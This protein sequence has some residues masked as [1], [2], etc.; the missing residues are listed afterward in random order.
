M[1]SSRYN[2]GTVNRHAAA[3]RLLAFVLLL[4]IGYGAGAEVAHDH[5][6]GDLVS[7][8]S[9]YSVQSNSD[10][11]SSSNGTR[12]RSECLT[13]QLH[14]NLCADTFHTPIQIDLPRGPLHHT[15]HQAAIYASHAKL[16][17]QG[18]GPPAS[19]L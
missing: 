6:T 7:V 15:Q 18:R 1:G 10:A 17:P 3:M 13:C 12:L 11:T 16:P 5:N 14:Q 9:S 2:S 8:M 19:F 4:C